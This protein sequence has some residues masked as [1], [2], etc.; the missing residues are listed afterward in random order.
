MLDH[1]TPPCEAVNLLDVF[2]LGLAVHLV[3][4]TR[5]LSTLVALVRPP[6]ALRLQI[7]ELRRE[8]DVQQQAAERLAEL[9]PCTDTW[10]ARSL[11]LRVLVLDHA[12]REDYL[13][14]ALDDYVPS[15]V[16]RGLVAEYATERMK[17]L[18]TTSP[19]AVARCM[20]V[21]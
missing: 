7:A 15:A 5:V 21:A 6:P 20:Q 17:L 3:A 13:R 19:L 12:K 14:A 16:G 9:E 10:Y 4:E 2:R 1:E 18:A 8:H 11:E